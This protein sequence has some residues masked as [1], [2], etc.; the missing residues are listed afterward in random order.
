[1]WAWQ[2]CCHQVLNLHYHLWIYPPHQGSR[3]CHFGEAGDPH[4]WSAQR[5]CC[6]CPRARRALPR[7]APVAWGGVAGPQPPSCN[8]L[9]LHPHLAYPLG[10]LGGG[11]ANVG[12][13]P[14]RVC[15]GCCTRPRGPAP[16]LAG[17]CG[18]QRSQQWPLGWLPDFAQLPCAFCRAVGMV[19]AGGCATGRALPRSTRPALLP[20]LPPPCQHACTSTR[21]LRCGLWRR[22]EFDPVDSARIQTMILLCRLNI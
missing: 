21:L 10:G 15:V 18:G 19:P 9:G 4:R 12:H 20:L 5:G 8:A 2:A 22:V 11:S 14:A 13:V 16:P 3:H 1:M 6:P 7:G 17:M